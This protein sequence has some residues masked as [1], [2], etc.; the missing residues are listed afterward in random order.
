MVRYQAQVTLEESKLSMAWNLTSMSPR[1]C[2]DAG[3][4]RLRDNSDDPQLN[5]KKSCF[6]HVYS[7]DKNLALNFGRT[8]NLQ[9]FDITTSYPNSYPWLPN[10]PWH[11]L[12]YCFIDSSRA[13]SRVYENSYSAH[14]QRQGQGSKEESARS[15]AAEI[16]RLIA[17]CK[18]RISSKIRY[19]T[20]TKF[21]QG[22]S[23][24]VPY[25]D[26]FNATVGTFLM[27]L[28]SILALTYSSMRPAHLGNALDFSS[29]C[30]ST[31]RTCLQLHCE[32]STQFMA[33][34]DNS[35]RTYI[36]WWVGFIPVIILLCY[37][38]RMLPR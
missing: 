23:G 31:A 20:T 15:I 35:W 17:I 10:T 7:L 22:D 18:V 34:T 2:L 1:L 37:T 11:T 5:Y 14:G 9:D 28:Y 6:W 30:I 19:T 8:S 21:R 38:L 25:S 33:R 4:H 26:E 29:E 32:L 24:E 36:G 3:L 13:R 12:S 27:T 16:G